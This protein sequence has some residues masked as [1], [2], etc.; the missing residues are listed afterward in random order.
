MFSLRLRKL[1]RQI[2]PCDS[3]IHNFECAERRGPCREYKDLAMIR[4]EIIDINDA[5][6]AKTSTRPKDRHENNP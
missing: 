1:N 5:Y 3:C 4:R 6:K 2:N